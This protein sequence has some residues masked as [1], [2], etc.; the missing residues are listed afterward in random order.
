MGIAELEKAGWIEVRQTGSHKHFRHPNRSNTT[1][2][3]H[4]RKDLA[5]KT[6]KS[7]ERQSGVTLR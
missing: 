3:L 4:P 1:T 6:L 2:V 5:L 7:I